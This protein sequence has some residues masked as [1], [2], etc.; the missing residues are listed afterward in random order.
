MSAILSANGLNVAI[1]IVKAAINVGENKHENNEN[2]SWLKEEKMANGVS[3]SSM[4]S[5][6]KESYQLSKIFSM[7][8]LA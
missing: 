4:T 5:Q 7:A 6:L 1:I 8:S 2:G 3:A